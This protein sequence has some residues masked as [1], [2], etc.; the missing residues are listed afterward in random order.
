MTEVMAKMVETHDIA[1]HR[2][3]VGEAGNDI[4]VRRVFREIV[5]PQ[6]NSVAAAILEQWLTNRGVLDVDQLG[7][8]PKLWKD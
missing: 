6:V 5:E 8:I 7:E 3:T 2:A 1:Y 4:Q